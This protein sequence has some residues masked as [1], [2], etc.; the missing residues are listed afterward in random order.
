LDGKFIY[1]ISCE[2][3]REL[4]EKRERGEIDEKAYRLALR[5]LEF[6]WRE[7]RVERKSPPPREYS[8]HYEK[9][10]FLTAKKVESEE[11]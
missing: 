1:R 8:Q 11:E 4:R 9:S 6:K 5:K 3:K 2:R 10:F 7:W